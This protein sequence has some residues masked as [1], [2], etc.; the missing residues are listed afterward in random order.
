MYRIIYRYK[1]FYNNIFFF[2][3]NKNFVK[4]NNKIG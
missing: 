3:I 4:Y 2:K 1:T